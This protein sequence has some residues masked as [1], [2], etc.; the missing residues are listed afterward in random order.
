MHV[1]EIDDVYVRVRV[2]ACEGEGESANAVG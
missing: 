1:S 2:S